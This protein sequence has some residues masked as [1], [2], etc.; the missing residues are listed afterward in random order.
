[1]KKNTILRVAEI[2]VMGGILIA[3]IAP[4][5]VHSNEPAGVQR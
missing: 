3:F 2:L 4:L 5:L 1:V